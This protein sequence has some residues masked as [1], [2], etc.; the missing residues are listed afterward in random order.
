MLTIINDVHIGAQRASGTTPLTQWRLRQYLLQEF[1]KLVVSVKGP[2]VILGDLFDTGHI[3][4]VDVLATWKILRERCKQGLVLYLVNGNHDLE[5]TLTNLSSF[6]FLCKVLQTEFPDTVHVIDQPAKIGGAYDSIYVIPHLPNQDLF[7][8]ALEAVPACQ[9]L[10]VHCNYDNKF[11]VQSDHSLNMS[12][13][14]AMACKAKYIIFAHE[15]QARTAL[16]GKVFVAGNQ[17][18]SSV[19]DCLGNDVKY[20]TGLSDVPGR[21][22]TWSRPGEYIE[23]DWRA[24]IDGGEKFIRVVGKATAAEAGDV[25]SAISRFRN[26]SEAL[27]ITNATEVEGVA[28]AE[29]IAITLEQ[30]ESFDVMQALLD[31]LDPREQKVVT[32]L[33]KSKESA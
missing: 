3:P 1:E 9:Y 22:Q 6:Q 20:M 32:D 26:K 10:L 24:L 14:Q 18:P 17:F 15:H 2:L 11:A 16:G 12:L 27:V 23:R 5:K 21:M 4:M 8:L 30:V 25:V 29:Q 28:D 31:C 33:L 7:N 13:E 19:A